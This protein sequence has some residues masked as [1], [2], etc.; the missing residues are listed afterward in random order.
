MWLKTVGKHLGV[1][2]ET[3]KITFK[4]ALEYRIAFLMQVGGMVGN[5]IAHI[6]L[7][8]F[9]FQT[10]P[11]VNGWGFHDSM[12]LF[13][14]MTMS[15]G[16]LFTLFGG[17]MSIARSVT[18]GEFDHFLTFP[19]SAL[20]NILISKT[21]LAALGDFTF[22]LLVLPIFVHP[23]LSELPLLIIS[24]FLST[25]IFLNCVVITQSLAFFLGDF[26]DAADNF[27]HLLLGFGLFPQSGFTGSLRIV[28]M[29]II[30]AFFIVTLPVEILRHFTWDGLLLLF[31]YACGSGIV[32]LFVFHQGLKRYESGNLIHIKG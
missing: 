32:A 9:F 11:V 8:A 31:G 3:K 10:F 4:G 12:I 1:L 18:T 20:W 14:V 24:I 27:F 2:W 26:E 29:T 15:F 13:S 21:D 6:I 16:I 22:G 19:L 17:C 28:M 5:D 25:W 23:A 7:W 30:P